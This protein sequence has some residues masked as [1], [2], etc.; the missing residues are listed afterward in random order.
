MNT[1][2]Q[3]FND[4]F[5]LTTIGA[6]IC[7]ISIV[8]FSVAFADGHETE[9]EAMAEKPMEEKPKIT[10]WFQIDVDSL[11]T[12]FLV[13]ASHPLSGGISFDSNIYVNDH[14]GEV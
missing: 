7:M 4:L 2:T 14:L 13:G 8:G 11:G 9:G 6:L 5:R 10:G 3:T 1:Y 12:Y